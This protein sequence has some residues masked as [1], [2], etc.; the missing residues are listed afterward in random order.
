V[1]QQMYST[2]KTVECACPDAGGAAAKP[3]AND[4]RSL[5]T[6]LVEECLKSRPVWLFAISYFL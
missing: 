4:E 3:R 5:V 2:A 1:Y 6:I